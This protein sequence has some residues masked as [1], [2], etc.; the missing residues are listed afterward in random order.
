MK[1]T[2]RMKKQFYILPITENVYFSCGEIMENGIQAPSAH[3]TGDPNDPFSGP[4]APV[5]KLYL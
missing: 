5:R 4:G 2:K 3:A 1:Q